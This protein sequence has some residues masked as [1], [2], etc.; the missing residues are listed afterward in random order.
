MMHLQHRDYGVDLL[1]KELKQLIE[2]V[3]LLFAL[4]YALD[5]IRHLAH[6]IGSLPLSLLD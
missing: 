6:Q 2:S 5:H 4:V 1:V 3:V